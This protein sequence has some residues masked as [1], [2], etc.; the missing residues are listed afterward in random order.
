MTDI[1]TATKP[2]AKRTRR[3][4][5][6]P[7]TAASSQQRQDAGTSIAARPAPSA[8]TKSSRIEAMLAWK[9]G[10]TL[11]AMCEA[12]GWQ[13]HTCRAFLTGLRKKG[14]TIE[15]STIDGVSRYTIAT[16]AETCRI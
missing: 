5:R 3:M 11:E 16:V 1:A 2:A 15:R 8:P 9:E 6:E 13:P 7:K 12:T 10:T 4:A 14:R